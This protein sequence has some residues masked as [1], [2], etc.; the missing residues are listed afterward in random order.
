VNSTLYSECRSRRVHPAYPVHFSR[1]VRSRRSFASLS[2]SPLTSFSSA[3]YPFNFELSTFNSLVSPLFVAFP[4]VSSVTPLSSA[5]TYLHGG[6]GWVQI[7]LSIFRTPICKPRISSYL[8][9]ALSPTP[10]FSQPS[11]L[12]GGGPATARSYSFPPSLSAFSP[13]ALS[14]TLLPCFFV[15]AVRYNPALTSWEGDKWLSHLMKN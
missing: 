11:A 1:R 7:G 10:V 12:P 4:Y 3:V 13:Q 8:R 15:A 14:C 5:F 9:I 6:G 2:T